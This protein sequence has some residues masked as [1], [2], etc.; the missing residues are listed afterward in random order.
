MSFFIP[1]DSEFRPPS[2]SV[3]ILNTKRIFSKLLFLKKQNIVSSNSRH[4]LVYNYR[5]LHTIVVNAYSRGIAI[6][7]VSK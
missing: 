5:K 1:F 3:I 7:E 6:F 2:D 4:L